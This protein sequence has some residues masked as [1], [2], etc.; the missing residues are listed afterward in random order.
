[1][2]AMFSES[3]NIN[4]LEV[5]YTFLRSLSN[6]NCYSIEITCGSESVLLPEVS[7]L[8]QEAKGFF[9]LLVRGAVTPVSAEDVLEDWKYSNS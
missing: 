7:D 2:R 1:M 6:K 9:D 8:Y 5:R 3:V 4:C